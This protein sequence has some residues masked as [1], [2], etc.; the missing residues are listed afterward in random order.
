[1]QA[2]ILAKQEIMKWSKKYDNEQPLLDKKIETEVGNRLRATRELS[3]DDLTRIIEWKFSNLK[4]RLARVTRYADRNDD[5][6]LRKVSKLVFDLGEEHDEHK[7]NLLC[8]FDGIG[9]A[10]A[11]V[12]LTFY[13]P[14]NY[15][16]FDIH[17]WREL[18]G[19]EPKNLF[20][21]KN[22]LQVLTQLRKIGAEYNLP[23]RKVEKAYFQ[24]NYDKEKNHQST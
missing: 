2:N 9:A 6:V 19:A 17:A 3:K 16:V 12:I 10:I 5:T 18:F 1:M 22:C 15:G 13:D 24:K 11:S 21:A 4:G 14:Q 8:V 7:I 20:T 23:A